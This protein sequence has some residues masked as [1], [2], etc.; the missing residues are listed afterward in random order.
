MQPATPADA[1]TLAALQWSWRVTEWDA[2]PDRDHAA[3]AAAFRDW[4]LSHGG[5]H[6]AMV[7]RRGET[8]A[9]MGWLAFVE[10][11]PTPAQFLRRCGHIQAMYVAPDHRGQGIGTAILESLIDAARSEGLEYL[12]VHPSPRSARFYARAG[13]IATEEHLVRDL[14]VNAGA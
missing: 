6:R 9:G 11:T 8:V 3:F 13:F 12:L 2:K 14:R 1:E 5:S 10:R 7:A 4:M